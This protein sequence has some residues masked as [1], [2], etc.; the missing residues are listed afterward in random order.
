VTTSAAASPFI[1][2]AI[3]AAIAAAASFTGSAEAARAE[4]RLLSHQASP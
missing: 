4:L 1:G 3:L 2:A